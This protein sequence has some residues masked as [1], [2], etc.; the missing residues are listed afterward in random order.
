MRLVVRCVSQLV[1]GEAYLLGLLILLHLVPIWSFSVFPSQDGPLHIA[2]AA[3]FQEY[4]NPERTAFR[5]Y[6]V[7]N[8]K[9][10]PNW[11]IQTILA[12]LLFFVSPLTAEKILL[13]GYTVLFPF[14]VRYA[15]E[16]IQRGSGFLAVVACIFI[17]NLFLHMGFYNFCYSLP[18][19]FFFLG[20]W[21]THGHE[22]CVRHLCMLVLLSVLLY[23]AH[24]VSFIAAL[25]AVAI[26]YGDKILDE[27]WQSAEKWWVSWSIDTPI[28]QPA[29]EQVPS[30]RASFA[31][32]LGGLLPGLIL[33]GFFFVDKGGVSAPSFSLTKSL[34]RL[35]YLRP[36]SS[37]VSFRFSEETAADITLSGFGLLIGYVLISQPRLLLTQAR[38]F[39]LLVIG[40]GCIFFIA[41]EA[42]SG[43]SF[44]PQRLTLYLALS[45]I[46]WLGVYRFPHRCRRLIQATASSITLLFLVLHMRTYVVLN[47]YLEEYRSCLSVLEANTT[48]LP[49]S[50]SHTGR[51]PDGQGLSHK[52]E[53]FRHASGY[54][55]ASRG[56]VTLD[57]FS[58]Y[59]GHHP[60]IYREH[61]R[62]EEY[63]GCLECI[64][65]SVDFMHYAEKTG[66]RVDYVLVWNVQD[67]DLQGPYA[68]SIFEQ[69]EEGYTLIFISAPRGML[70]LYQRNR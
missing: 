23:F 33:A 15:L 41:P 2:N 35:D 28:Q 36:F 22:P 61:L 65:P 63:I 9:P 10:S 46:L 54:F 31:L 27:I 5:E 38:A 49:L 3:T 52:A 11:L 60:L 21:I 4:H 59:K 48:L 30:R 57:N 66:G 29:Q 34:Q 40:Y 14:A 16:A 39:V 50:F 24:I 45:A 13:S 19:Y 68:Q 42:S 32:T 17:S 1:A 70:Q 67:T 51:A 25:I 12:G 18:L 55:V 47:D 64:P 6:Y 58:A 44:I 26:L 20:Y 37:L 69:L 43:G 7:L 56:I 8:K 62:P 53:P